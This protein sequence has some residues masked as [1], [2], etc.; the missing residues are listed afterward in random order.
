MRGQ[1]K[2]LCGP[3]HT[4]NTPLVVDKAFSLEDGIILVRTELRASVGRSRGHV[5]EVGKG[6]GDESHH[7]EVGDR[8]AHFR[9]L[10][11]FEDEVY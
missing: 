7:Q 4:H 1:R 3:K 5:S 6:E 9:L 11:Y 2:G 10:K 8:L